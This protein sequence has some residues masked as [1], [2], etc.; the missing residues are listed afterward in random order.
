MKKTLA[1]NRWQAI[2]EPEWPE[3]TEKYLSLDLKKLFHQ[4][5]CCIYT[6]LY[7][8]GVR[9]V[10]SGEIMGLVIR[11]AAGLDCVCPVIYRESDPIVKQVDFPW[12]KTVASNGAQCHQCCDLEHLKIYEIMFMER[13]KCYYDHKYS[14]MPWIIWSGFLQNAH[15]R[16]SVKLYHLSLTHWG[17]DKMAAIFQTTFC[18]AFCWMK[19]FQFRFRFHWSLF[20][21]VQLTIFHH[22]FG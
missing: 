1:L 18:N 11:D 6:Y 16:H 19:M 22:W 3:F 2:H 21:R 20:P 8:Y 13:L 12:Q 9:I 10:M 17:Q 4:K 7:C 14:E 15:R 5:A